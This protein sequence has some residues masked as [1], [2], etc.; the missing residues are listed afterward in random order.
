[1]QFVAI[2]RRRTEA[3]TD[4]EF[5]AVLE[6][7]AARARELYA[8][9]SFRAINSRGDVPGAVIAV[10]ATDLEEATRLVGTLPFVAGGLADAEIIPL[11]PY[12]V[13]IGG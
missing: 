2:V 8:Q 7:E 6:P 11:R 5:A 4:A 10:E 9:G 1:M 12:R 3:F 13:F